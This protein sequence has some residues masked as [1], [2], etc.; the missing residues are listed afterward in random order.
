MQYVYSFKEGNKDKKD[1]LG[2]KGAN[3]AE[4]A[5]LGLPIPDG[6]TVTTDACHEY[7]KNDK[8]IS[9]EIQFQILSKLK[10]LEISSHKTFGSPTNPLLV[11]VRSGAPV[12]MPGM[13][14]SIM[15]L[16]IND[17]ICEAMAKSN[18][19]LAY[20]SYRRFIEF[21][22]EV[23]MGYPTDLFAGYLEKYKETKGYKTDLELTSEDLRAIVI[24]YKDNYLE[25]GGEHFPE[26]P[27]TQLMNTIGAVF[28]SWN[29][30]RAKK[31]REVEGIS[32]DIGTA[33]NVQE[34][35]YG[36][37][38]DISATGVVFSRNPATGENELTGE[39]LL[40]AQGE[41]IVSGI[42]TPSNIQELKDFSE[43]V[44]NE[45]Y[46][47]AKLLEGHYKDVQDMEF[48]IENGKLFV[49][50]TRNGKRTPSAHIKFTLDLLKEKVI[51]VKTAFERITPEDLEILT[52]PSFSEESIKDAVVL[53][54][55]LAASPGV[56]IG[57]LV[58]NSKQ[59]KELNDKDSIL[60][61][62]ETSAEDI[63]G[64][65]YANGILT[66]NGGL[67]SH[68]AVVARGFGECCVC[69]AK[70]IEI[71]EANETMKIGDITLTK[72]DYISID[73]STGIVYKGK[74]ELSEAS[75]NKELLDEVMKLLKKY[76]TIKVRANA[77]TPEQARKALE[78]GA[79]GI[80]LVR[81]EHMFFKEERI[82]EMRKMI[83]AK[84]KRERTNA[85][86]NLENFQEND[87]YEILKVMNEYPVIIRY[88]DPPLH[89]FLPKEESEIEECASSLRIDT[90]EIIS[91]IDE[92]KE[93]NPMMGFRGCRLGVKY[94]EISIMQTRALIKAL[95]RLK[96]EGIKTDAKIMVPLTTDIKEFIYIRTIIDRT[97]KRLMKEAD[98]EVTYK[99]GTMIETPRA[100]VLSPI[101]SKYADFYSFGTNDL[102]QLSYGLSR[103][104]AA[105]FL[106]EYYDKKIYD[107]D[108]FKTLDPYGV[109]ELMR[110][111]KETASK[112]IEM[113]ICGEHGGDEESIRFAHSIG[114]DYVSCSPYRVLGARLASARIKV[115]K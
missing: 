44:Y 11:S 94:P 14:D 106:D 31:Y 110:I 96:R 74:L 109:G 78:F 3:L 72:D 108:P 70:E 25:Y 22:S 41:D 1:I 85:L 80:G 107:I 102:T 52:K 97:A 47:I 98:D 62:N 7:Y 19:R 82:L 24:K 60:V 33:V 2:G 67:T 20:D 84:D 105:K 51:D 54:K 68:A 86:A 29:N 46:R 5:S 28:A 89:E 99:V 73:G 9:S 16:G 45:L 112:K 101:I 23:V 61:R 21:Y 100:A 77:D 42:R 104:D 81:T 50:Q 39:Y 48:T 37:M 17:D 63:D 91:R 34:M 79:T 64:M 95:I 65:I 10:A 88:L 26:D 83:L 114:L 53:T 27:K 40:N 30:D 90:S 113:G 18:P 38:N 103:D 87:F 15:N 58:F 43:D 93:V 92:L 36:N 69:G 66:K 56:A 13:M 115:N 32:E 4:M 55:G 59:A 76:E 49:L 6:F 71:D 75:S 8:K 35:V 12:S 57:H 111:A